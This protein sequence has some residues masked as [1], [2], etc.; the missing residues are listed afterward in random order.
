MNTCVINL[1][2]VES[3]QEKERLSYGLSKFEKHMP[4]GIIQGQ[5][6]ASGFA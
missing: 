6:L 2:A 5:G 3:L 1:Q 4:V